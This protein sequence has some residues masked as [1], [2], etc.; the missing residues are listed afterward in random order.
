MNSDTAI[1]IAILCGGKSTRFGSECKILHKIDD[2]FMFQILYQKLRKFTTD[3]FLQLSTEIKDILDQNMDPGELAKYPTYLDIYENRGPLS[4]IYSALTN[5]KSP[6]V[7]VVAADL[8]TV[9]TSI[10]TEL[11]KYP[12]HQLVIPK[13]ASG[14]YE[15]LCAVYSQELLGLIKSQIELGKLSI[16]ELF[17]NEPEFKVKYVNIDELIENNV[18]NQD[19]F[20]N[21]NTIRDL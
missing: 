5:A 9:D 4:G 18:I 2:E 14:Y 16:H 13:W 7:F 12:G 21:I 8:P 10:L 19:C 17:E 6:L 15:P 3:I 1:S 20:K 11:L